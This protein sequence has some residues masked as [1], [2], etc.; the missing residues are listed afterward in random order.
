MKAN[1][2]RSGKD[3]VPNGI[4]EFSQKCK[5]EKNETYKINIY[6]SGRYILKINDRY[7]C[8]GPCKG[9]EHIRYYDSVETDSFCVGENEIKIIVMHINDNAFFISVFRS[10]RPEVIFEAKSETNII[11]CDESWKCVKNNQFELRPVPSWPYAA[12]YED[13]DFSN[14]CTSFSIEKF[15]EFDFEK[16]I[17]TICGATKIPKLSAR[18]IP[19]LFPDEEV[20]FTVVKSGE[21]FVELDAGKYITAKVCFEFNANTDV[22]IIYAERYKKEN[23]D[24]MCDDYINGKI[25]GYYDTVK[26]KGNVCYSPFWF[27]SFRYIRIE[28]A[29]IKNVFVSAKA[30]IW[31]YPLSLDG[32]FE[33]SDD[34]FNK[35]QEV[36]VNTMLCCTHDTFY[37]CP[38]YEQ[39]QYILDATIT[40]SI[41]MRMSKDVRMVKKCIEELAA[42]QLPS[43]LLLSAYPS[44]REQ[45][46]PGFSFFW[47]FMLNDY[48]E[49]TKD[50]E[51]ARKYIGNIDKI[52]EFFRR[53]CS[54][55]GL[56]TKGIYWD[57]VDWVDE[58]HIGEPAT[59]SGEVITIYTMYYA[60]ALLC[61]YNMCMKVGRKGLAEEYKEE[62]AKVKEAIKKH[63]FDKE[64]GMY[65]D[66]LN[67]STYSVHTIIWAIISEIETGEEA[68][69]LLSH[70]KDKDVRQPSDGFNY[71][72]FRALEKCDKVGEI[73]S[74]FNGWQEMLDM[75]CTTWREIPQK[76]SRSE[77]HA[78]SS[79][80]LYE[81]SSN[82][83]GVKVG[84]ED[85]I[86]IKPNLAGL[87]FAKGAV[88]TRFGM[89]NVSWT[90]GTNG[91][92][93]KIN[94]PRNVYK[95]V[96]MPDGRTENFSNTE[97][98]I[99]LN[100]K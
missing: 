61:A 90:N 13:V 81:F 43:G 60:S 29:G 4:Y 58:W 89:V 14:E 49:Y 64:K 80:P 69:K 74:N 83:L 36:S 26:T 5:I 21:D 75:H 33:C 79:A 8:E 65:K 32:S 9:H 37:D 28:A 10:L 23:D 54:E 70:L 20:D 92:E 72:L 56:V 91:F 34:N 88:P 77:C 25:D 40:A 22:K 76:N 12:P 46:I 73:F 41:L 86:I 1:F 39:L 44:V 17:E 87:T 57:F 94:A 19:M 48:L 27:R 98:D 68:E 99:T 2:I 18:P 96:I 38:Y 42:S 31:H 100:C 62:Y 11:T 85:E 78:W 30:R 84:F 82:I 67:K 7:I 35:M 66:T 50:I 51:T 47:I 63:C 95:K 55:E 6:T 93:I 52:F 71:F 97:T 15:G 53:N 45:I 3:F 16:G 24:G 59:A